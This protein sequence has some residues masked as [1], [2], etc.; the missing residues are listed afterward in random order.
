MID[1]AAEQAVLLVREQIAGLSECLRNARGES[2]RGAC[3]ETY[4]IEMF[5]IW[6]NGGVDMVEIVEP[7]D[8]ERKLLPMLA[9]IEPEDVIVDPSCGG[10]PCVV[11]VVGRRGTL[12]IT[13]GIPEL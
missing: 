2:E 6:K 7:D 8:I 12:I 1:M 10:K 13:Q 3:L 4:G 11:Y 9:A 5:I